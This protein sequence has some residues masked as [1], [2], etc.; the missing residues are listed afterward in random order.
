[1][2]SKGTHEPR[3]IGRAERPSGVIHLHDHRVMGEEPDS[4]P[5]SDPEPTPPGAPGQRLGPRR[6]A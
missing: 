6:A 3:W 5:E 2:T 4:G 1:M